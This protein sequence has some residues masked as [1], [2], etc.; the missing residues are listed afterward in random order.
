MEDFNGADKQFGDLIPAGSIVP[1]YLH[2]KPGGAGNGGFLTMSRNTD[3]QYINAEFAVTEGP[4]AKRR[5]FENIVVS[6]GKTNEKGESIAANISRSKIRAMLES[7]RNIHPD[8]SSPRAI[9]ARQINSW[10]DLEGL[11]FLAK[12]GVEKGSENYP[13]KNKIALVITPDKPEYKAGGPAAGSV[14]A[15]VATPAVPAS[16]AWAS[17][18]PAQMPS[19]PAAAP[20]NNPTPAWAR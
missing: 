4:F 12:V 19:P 11:V 3:A 15:P 2:I 10:G 20:V 14:Q 8:D 7:A 16:P 1:L 13:D 9:S 6:G 5:I 18:S 17:A